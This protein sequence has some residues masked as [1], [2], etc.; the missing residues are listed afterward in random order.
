MIVTLLDTGVLWAAIDKRDKHHRVATDL[1]GSIPG[2]LLLPTTVL[3]ETAWNVE[4]NLG[5]KAEAE[6]IDDVVQSEMEIVELDQ[7]DII[8]AASFIRQYASLSLGFV[9]A[10]VMALAQRLEISRIATVDRRH[11]CAV[12]PKH[13][14]HFTLLP[15]SI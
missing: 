2:R 3:T 7:Q 13:V 4:S 14:D 11:F 9:D 5:S 10:S 1:L 8:C 15:E 12:R 6:F